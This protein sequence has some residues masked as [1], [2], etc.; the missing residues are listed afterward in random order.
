MSELMKKLIEE[1]LKN[2]EA[3]KEQNI[4]YSESDA[5][6]LSQNITMYSTG[7]NLSSEEMNQINARLNAI[8]SEAKKDELFIKNVSSKRL[9]VKEKLV[10]FLKSKKGISALATLGATLGMSCVACGGLKNTT[11]T[12]EQPTEI[13]TEANTEMIEQEAEK[14]LPSSMSEEI[15][16]FADTTV[17]SADDALTSGINL[18]LSKELTEADKETYATVLTQYRIVANMDD[19]TK[20][21]Y[22]ELFG[23]MSNPTEDLMN[24]FMNYNTEIKKHLITVSSD[25]LLD[26]SKLYNK[27]KDAEVLNYSEDVIAKMNDASTDKERLAAAKEWYSYA[28]N[29]L[30]ST[31]G[32][33]ALSSQALD[34][35]ITHSEAYDELTRSRYSSIQGAHIDDELEHK[36]NIAKD[37]CLG[38]ESDSNIDVQEVGIENL[39]STF[40]I[41]II[42]K[43]NTKYEDAISERELQLNIGNTLNSY[44]TYDQVVSYVESNIDLSKYVA[45]EVDY[46]EKQK[47]EKGINAP[48]QKSKYDSGVSDGQGGHIDERQFEQYGIDSSSPTAKTELEQAVQKADIEYSNNSESH[49]ITDPNGNVVSKGS[50]A[51]AEEYNKGVQDGANARNNYAGIADASS[52]R[53]APSGT[54]SN[55]V[56]GWYLGWDQADSAIKQAINDSKTSNETTYVPVENGETTTTETEETKD[57]TETPSINEPSDSNI[58]Y[59]T[60]FEPIENYQESVEDSN[61]EYKTT[62]EPVEQTDIESYSLD[63]EENSYSVEDEIAALNSLKEEL[64]SN[65]FDVEVSKVK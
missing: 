36:F 57:Y 41:S 44:N 37:V 15:K 18:S 3:K 43:L 16:E 5:K 21:Q 2:F 13:V 6:N 51:N 47:K 40:R 29:I 60:T 49:T 11:Q 39:K 46:V 31:E 34:T 50:E 4:A 48:A 62:F 28:T 58:K 7:A 45:V 55:Y 1:Q 56:S 25:N 52:H 64:L 61:I 65:S 63:S 32:N 10:N 22:A 8:V 14:V 26:Y 24:N 59:D 38:I 27:E 20:L 23:E 33:I 35:L 42:E 19:I 54:S 9:P 12:T 17:L 30:T 53:N